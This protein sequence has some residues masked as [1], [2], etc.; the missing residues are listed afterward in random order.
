[1]ARAAHHGGGD[2]TGRPGGRV[3]T[4]GPPAQ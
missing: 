2:L 4:R 3:L 1:V